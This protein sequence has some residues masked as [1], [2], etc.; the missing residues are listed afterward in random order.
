MLIEHDD[1]IYEIA[2]ELKLS[3]DLVNFV[4]KDYWKSVRF[5]LVN[6][7][8][9]K[10]GVLIKNFGKF[11]IDP[12]N[13]ETYIKSGKSNTDLDYNKLLKQLKDEKQ[14]KQED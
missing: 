5:H 6:P 14:T 7:Y 10:Q 12:Y 4:I 1:V 13:V 2:R 3:E 9:S 8:E 11:Y